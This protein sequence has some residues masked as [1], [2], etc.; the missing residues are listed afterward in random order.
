MRALGESGLAVEAADRA[1]RALD[2]Y[3]RAQVAH[4]E[5]E[6]VCER[7]VLE[8]LAVRYSKHDREAVRRARNAVREAAS[9]GDPLL[10]AEALAAYGVLHEDIDIAV[11]GAA[12]DQAVEVLGSIR[13]A[14]TR[15]YVDYLH[16][17]LEETWRQDWHGDRSARYREI[18]EACLRAGD[19]RRAAQSMRDAA[20][21]AWAPRDGE[22]LYERAA[23]MAEPLGGYWHAAIAADHLSAMHAR[24]QRLD[25]DT[26]L[27]ELVV[28]HMSLLHVATRDLP[29]Q[30]ARLIDA[31]ARVAE[32]FAARD[33]GVPAPRGRLV[34][35]V[36]RHAV[37][38]LIRRRASWL[39]GELSGHI[40]VYID[41]ARALLGETVPPTSLNA[42]LRRSLDDASLPLDVIRDARDAPLRIDGMSPGSGGMPVVAFDA[43]RTSFISG[44]VVLLQRLAQ[45]SESSRLARVARMVRARRA[46]GPAAKFEGYDDALAGIPDDPSFTLQVLPSDDSIGVATRRVNAA[47][48]TSAIDL[49]RAEIEEATLSLKGAQMEWPRFVDVA[50]AIAARFRDKGEP[51]IAAEALVRAALLL[52]ENDAPDA[53]LDAALALL[54]EAVTAMDSIGDPLTSASAR[55]ARISN[56]RSIVRKYAAKN[57]RKLDTEP[58]FVEW[59]K[60]LPV[61][62][63]LLVARARP[64][65]ALSIAASFPDD[66]RDPKLEKR[67]LDA[68]VAS[69]HGTEGFELI[70]VANERLANDTKAWTED[71][72]VSRKASIDAYEKSKTPRRSLALLRLRR[73][74]PVADVARYIAS[75][76]ASATW[77]WDHSEC[78]VVG[79]E[80][81]RRTRGALDPK[82]FIPLIDLGIGAIKTAQRDD[83]Y[84]PPNLTIAVASLAARVGDFERVASALTHV[85]PWQLDEIQSIIVDNP[86]LMGR[87]YLSIAEGIAFDNDDKREGLMAAATALYAE[88]AFDLADKLYEKALALGEAKTSER[89]TE[90]RA[91][92]ARAAKKTGRPGAR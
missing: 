72:E 81:V 48:R 49:A 85:R 23:K 1:A 57:G 32:E 43:L 37:A 73:D 2:A 69:S 89:M 42:R 35:E 86:T 60:K 40:A 51:M 80:A 62:V 79:V 12:L 70:G 39:S 90:L 25:A 9:C 78:F 22:A 19:T 13:L 11:A 77:S 65:E 47:R 76:V 14:P 75:C 36:E 50:R 46:D 88:G 55:I 34:A 28:R 41:R 53:R 54:G 63:E 83:D 82:L 21:T 44:D 5:D 56:L 45:W 30:D 6:D 64:S 4:H 67:C 58:L 66:V 20:R 18:A 29:S 10:L 8:V 59:T 24:G 31:E 17:Q 33:P 27:H 91:A 74:A 71:R 16:Y 87:Y 7:G 61:L 52:D 84:V 26:R 68:L 3:H 38:L 92:R 15:C